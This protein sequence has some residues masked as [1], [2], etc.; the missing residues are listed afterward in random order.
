MISRLGISILA[1]TLIGCASTE[2][3]SGTAVVPLTESET[4]EAA[5]I[6]PVVE[7]EREMS[8]EEYVVAFIAK[9][10]ARPSEQQ[11]PN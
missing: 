3:D 5:P 9:M 8:V 1:A 10:D 4:H 7:A 11:L 6:D 2:K